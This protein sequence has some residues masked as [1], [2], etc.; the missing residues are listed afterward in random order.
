MLKIRGHYFKLRKNEIVPL[1]IMGIIVAISSLALFVAYN[2]MEAG[3]A[4]TILFVYPIMV[5]V[6]MAAI[7]H[8]K[9]TLQT[10]LCIIMALGG[11]I[12]LY[13]GGEEGA[14]LSLTGTLIVLGAAFAYSL[15][16]VGINRPIFKHISFDIIIKRNESASFPL[17]I[18]AFKTCS[19]IEGYYIAFNTA[20]DIKG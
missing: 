20:C 18:I 8:E 3:I 13:D 16:I 4:S 15:Y 17:G 6:I 12:L 10:I 9:L 7:Y 5:A 2:Y 19:S 14:T 11:I 1:I